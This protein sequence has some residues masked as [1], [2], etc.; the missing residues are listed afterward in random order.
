MFQN[1]LFLV[2]MNSL[3]IELA[4]YTANITEDVAGLQHEVGRLQQ[5]VGDGWAAEE[6]RDVGEVA[7]LEEMRGL[8]AGMGRILEDIRSGVSEQ[9]H[10]LLVQQQ[11]L[12]EARWLGVFEGVR[13]PAAAIA[14]LSWGWALGGWWMPLLSMVAFA[15]DPPTTMLIVGGT[16]VK[17]FFTSMGRC[18]LVWWCCRRRQAATPGEVPLGPIPDTASDQVGAPTPPGWGS[19][20]VGGLMPAWMRGGEAEVDSPV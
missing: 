7:R 13:S 17:T 10:M 12:E 19:W 4:R 20:L 5:L 15:C 3:R 1:V 14:F 2:R 11:R 18:C 16:L 6:R 9:R 8:H